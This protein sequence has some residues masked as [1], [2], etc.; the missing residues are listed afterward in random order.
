MPPKSKQEKKEIREANRREQAAK[1]KEKKRARDQGIVPERPGLIPAPIEIAG[2]GDPDDRD[3]AAIAREAR[4]TAIDETLLRSDRQHTG[5]GTHP[6]AR[7][8]LR[9]FRSRRGGSL[10]LIAGKKAEHLRVEGAHVS[11]VYPKEPFMDHKRYERYFDK[12]RK[13]SGQVALEKWSER[14]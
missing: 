13:G 14:A 11:L 7:N 10:T 9:A 1:K 8:I 12:L 2:L 3:E 6:D 4:N 5:W